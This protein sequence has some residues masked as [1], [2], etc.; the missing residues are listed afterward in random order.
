MSQIEWRK[1]RASLLAKD[2]PAAKAEPVAAPVVVIAPAETAV[3]PDVF[4]P[5]VIQPIPAIQPDLGDIRI[6][7][8]P[9]EPL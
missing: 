7:T 6:G 9:V 4:H 1:R 3:E 2:R 5:N 8:D